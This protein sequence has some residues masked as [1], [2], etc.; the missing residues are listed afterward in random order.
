MATQI[1]NTLLGP[2]QN[3]QSANVA[4]NAANTITVSCGGNTPYLAGVFARLWFLATGNEWIEAA[5][6]QLTPSNP[7]GTFNLA[8][9]DI[10]ALARVTGSNFASGTS[11]LVQP[12]KGTKGARSSPN[13]APQAVW[14][15]VFND[16]SYIINGG[17]S[18]RSVSVTASYA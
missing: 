10:Q 18:G 8:T 14:S 17:L 1:V 5:A 2:G 13:T 12:G 11:G 4:F 3:V 16:V 7:S 9:V 15:V 6:L